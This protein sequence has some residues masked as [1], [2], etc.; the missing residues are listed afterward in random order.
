MVRPTDDLEAMPTVGGLW[1]G[2]F[3]VPLEREGHVGTGH[4]IVQQLRISL[5]DEGFPVFAG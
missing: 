5:T 4:K 2:F 3:L 1:E